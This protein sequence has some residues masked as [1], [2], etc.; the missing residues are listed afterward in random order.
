MCSG[1]VSCHRRLGSE[2]LFVPRVFR[3]DRRRK[4]RIPIAV[5][6][7]CGNMWSCYGLEP[8]RGQGRMHSVGRDEGQRR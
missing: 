4:G 1:G 7:R 6:R 2:C 3:R 5:G 8:V